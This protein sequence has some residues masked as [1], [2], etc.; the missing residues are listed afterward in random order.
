MSSILVE[1][2]INEKVIGKPP[3]PESEMEYKQLFR[4]IN[5][6]FR[7]KRLSID[8]F[9][10]HIH[11]GHAYTAQLYNGYRHSRNFKQ[12]QH[13]GFDLDHLSI[14]IEDINDPLILNHASFLHT[15][16]SD[17]PSSPRS[18][19]VFVLDTPI[20]DGETYSAI[21]Q[22]MHRA[23]TIEIDEICKDY[24]RLFYG[25]TNCR[26]RYFGN[27][28]RI[29]DLLKIVSPYFHEIKSEM[30]LNKTMPVINVHSLNGVSD[31]TVQRKIESAIKP[32]LTCS[33]GTKH[34]TLLSVSRLVGGYVPHYVDYNQA[35]GIL[36]SAIMQRKVRSKSAAIETIKKGLDYGMNSPI[37]ISTD[38]YMSIFDFEYFN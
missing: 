8:D 9:I 35:A 6:N 18:R 33:D 27:V 30:E 7:N 32:I 12:A 26:I 16:S 34:K 3:I 31:L 5:S 19:A 25:A 10:Q 2:A 13:I 14:P 36:E 28:L 20:T 38:E 37:K 1:V 15:T 21:V 22:S 11:S 24:V 17:S 23:S 29:A 4:H